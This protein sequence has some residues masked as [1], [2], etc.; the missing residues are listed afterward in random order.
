MIIERTTVDK[1]PQKRPVVAGVLK[2]PGRPREENS[3]SGVLRG[4]HVNDAVWIGVPDG[5]DF[6][7][8]RNM[9]YALVKSCKKQTGAEFT[10]RPDRDGNRVAVGR[11]A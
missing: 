11:V 5:R 4:L 9:L 1:L 6:E 8:Y 7:S 10:I 2:Y 3:I